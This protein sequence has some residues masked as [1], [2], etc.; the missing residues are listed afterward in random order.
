MPNLNGNR[1]RHT[2][3][4]GHY[5]KYPLS[6]ADIFWQTG[7]NPII[8]ESS[9]RGVKKALEKIKDYETP[10]KE[11]VKQS[12]KPPLKKNSKKRAP[13]TKPTFNRRGKRG[14]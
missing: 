10:K 2:I 8:V 6:L 5:I 7:F 12:I 4:K 13:Q 1:V 3:N 14:Q 11:I 9:V